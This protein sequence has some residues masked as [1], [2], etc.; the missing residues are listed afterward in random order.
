MGFL[1]CWTSTLLGVCQCVLV[2]E[3]L[4]CVH[5]IRWFRVDGLC[6]YGLYFSCILIRI[7]GCFL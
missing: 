2:Q 4:E 6:F 7:L 3:C 1:Q 5:G